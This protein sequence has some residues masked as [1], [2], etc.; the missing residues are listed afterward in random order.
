MR[1]A[2]FQKNSF[3]DYPGKMA[4]VIFTPGCNM[5]CYYCHNRSLIR[6]DKVK[7]LYHHDA[8]LDFLD[9]RKGFLDGVVITGGEPTLQK[10]LADFIREVK[11]LGYAVKLDTN[12]TNPDVLKDLM[13]KGLLDY[14]AMDIKAPP[15]RYEEICGVKIEWKDIYTSIQI[16]LQGNIEYEFR[17]T[18]APSLKEEDVLEMARLVQGARLYAL[19][20][21]RRPDINGYWDERLSQPPHTGGEI[22]EWAN[23]ISLL[24]EKCITRGV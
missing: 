11:G 22:K 7:S 5:N 13:N 23:K 12:G 19:Q 6:G 24:V 15:S 14:V 16:L 10:G 20:Q 3:I 17:T 18:L 2:G 21:Y 4:A 1:I 8:I 9:K